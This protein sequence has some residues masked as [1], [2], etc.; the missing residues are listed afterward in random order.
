LGRVRFNA[1]RKTGGIKM[2]NLKL[3]NDTL[4]N[5]LGHFLADHPE[6]KSQT[7]FIEQAIKEKLERETNV[8]NK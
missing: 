7:Q 8:G 4:E 6:Y 3:K 1:S 5:Q 2:I